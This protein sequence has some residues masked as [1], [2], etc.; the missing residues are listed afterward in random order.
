MANF[1]SADSP[2]GE[3]TFWLNASVNYSDLTPLNSDIFGPFTIITMDQ[4]EILDN[5][6]W[7]PMFETLPQD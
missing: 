3:F 4:D 2:I 6:K 5:L 7:A 1:K